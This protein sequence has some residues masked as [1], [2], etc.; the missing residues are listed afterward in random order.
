MASSSF[1]VSKRRRRHVSNTR[2]DEARA[3]VYL[4]KVIPVMPGWESLTK[5]SLGFDKTIDGL[6]KLRIFKN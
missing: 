6:S 1:A 2:P 5:V 4:L 3:T